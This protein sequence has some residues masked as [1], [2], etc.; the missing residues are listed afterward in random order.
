MPEVVANGVIDALARVPG[1]VVIGLFWTRVLDVR[2]ARVYWGAWFLIWLVQ[3]LFRP[4]SEMNSAASVALFLVQMVVFPL[5]VAR[6]KLWYR[7]LVLSATTLGVIVSEFAVLLFI[8]ALGFEEVP[9]YTQVLDQPAEYFMAQS[10]ILVAFLLVFYLLYRV[11]ARLTRQQ[12]SPLFR[13]YAAGLFGQFLLAYILVGFL[14]WFALDSTFALAVTS[15]FV[16]VNLIADVFILLSVSRA[17]AAYAQQV[18]ARRFRA[19]LDGALTHYR[20]LADEIQSVARFRHDLRD[21]LQTV[22]FLVRRGDYARA[23]AL[24][25]EMEGRLGGAAGKR[26]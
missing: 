23:E 7:V 26:R 24:V 20:S 6:D 17:N 22:A 19:T 3:S 16:L 5:A 14:E 8:L 4:I 2:D 11:F 12:A 25:D 15:A 10:L 1:F 21:G 9:G 13:S 18:R